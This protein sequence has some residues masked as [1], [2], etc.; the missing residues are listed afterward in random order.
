[1]KIFKGVG[2]FFG[3]DIGTKSVRI[4]Q[5][6]RHGSGQNSTFSLRAFGYAPLDEQTAQANSE[7]SRKKLGDV[8]LTVLGQ[9]GIKTKNVALA[10]PSNKTFT[11]VIDVP[12]QSPA[13]LAKTIKYQVDQYIP[14]SSED[15][16][17]DWAFLGPSPKDPARQ[18]V[19]LASAAIEYSEE[20]LEFI[21]NLGLNI[22]AIEPDQ[23]AMARSLNIHDPQAANI[24]I[25]MGEQTTD[26]AVAYNHAPRLLRSLPVG[27]STM[28]RTA[29]QNLDVKEDQARQFILKF[30]LAPDKLEGRVYQSIEGVLDNFASELNKSAKFFQTKYPNIPIAR[31]IVSGYAGVIPM[32]N[33][34]VANKVNLTTT[35]GSPWANMNLNQAQ[36]QTLAPIA[37]EFAVAVGLAQRSNDNV[38]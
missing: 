33:N 24:I 17:V 25:D 16:K 38:R 2:D 28:V 21:E 18:E 19:L 3:L 12:S 23:I 30:G 4:V 31:V 6:N 13:E 32:M 8:I 10:V 26:M 1:M 22:I 7:V 34:Y 15:A 14:M 29:A 35:I 9:S 20:R 5:L 36:Q 37:S 11:T 27:L